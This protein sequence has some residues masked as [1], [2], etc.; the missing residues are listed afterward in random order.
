MRS[1]E[2]DKAELDPAKKGINFV[3]RKPRGAEGPDIGKSVL[4]TIE[5]KNV[6]VR[7]VLDEIAKQSGTRYKIDE[8][9]LTFVPA[10]EKDP[11]PLTREQA[12]ALAKTSPPTGPKTFENL[13]LLKT[14]VLPVVDFEDV[15]LTEAVAFLNAQIKAPYGAAGESKIKIGPN[16]KGDTRIKELRLRNVPLIEALKYCCDAVKEK[17]SVTDDG[18]QIGK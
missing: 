16:T 12:E 14:T 13:E 10:D 17:F 1:R 11:V 5:L 3:I 6:T 7:R 9:A 8:Y 4:L 2:L 15:T 18:V